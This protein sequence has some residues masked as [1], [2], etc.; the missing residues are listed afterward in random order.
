[1]M[2][3]RVALAVLLGIFGVAGQAAAQS[4]MLSVDINKAKLVVQWAPDGNSGTPDRFIVK[5]GSQ[6]GVY[7]KTSEIAFP[8][9][10]LAAKDAVT[11][12]GPQFCVASA[13]NQFGESAT[14]PEL[15][16]FVGSAPSGTIGLGLKVQ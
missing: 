7:T 10:E 5:C 14:T 9:T 3:F 16:F 8:A 4:Q 2:K 1:M 6:S 15:A 12:P 13:A 11:G